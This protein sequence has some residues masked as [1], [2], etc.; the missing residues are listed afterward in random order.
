MVMTRHHAFFSP[1]FT[2]NEFQDSDERKV[3]KAIENKFKSLLNLV[4]V[5]RKPKTNKP[6]VEEIAKKIAKEDK[7][8]LDSLKD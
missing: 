6:T 7:E 5:W 8:L 4:A 3:E 2:S 1:Y